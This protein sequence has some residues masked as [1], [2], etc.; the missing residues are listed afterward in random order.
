MSNA[1]YAQNPHY[2]T[3]LNINIRLTNQFDL[4]QFVKIIHTSV[5]VLTRR[6]TT[7]YDNRSSYRA[8]QNTVEIVVNVIINLNCDIRW[9]IVLRND[10]DA[11]S[12][13]KGLRKYE[14]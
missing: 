2:I 5:S 6:N 10:R 11:I 4:L 1:T 14:K 9:S 8:I 7:S 13:I 12:T 3:F